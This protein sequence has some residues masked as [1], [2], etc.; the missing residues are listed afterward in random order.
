MDIVTTLVITVHVIVS[1]LLIIVVLLQP[2]TSGDLGSIFGGST[3]SIFGATGAVPFLT[4]LTRILALIFLVTS[5]SLGYMSTKKFRSS[6][7]PRSAEIAAPPAGMGAPA[8][9]P[10]GASE[11]SGGKS[12]TLTEK[13]ERGG[14]VGNGGKGGT[15]AEPRNPQKGETPAK[16]GDKAAGGGGGE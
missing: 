8:A 9:S 14:N 1:L 2:G 13:G 16:G 6:V 10:E 15:S 5:L 7:I 3:Q 12:G 4:K 11:A